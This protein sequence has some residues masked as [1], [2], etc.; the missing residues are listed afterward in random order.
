MRVSAQSLTR[1]AHSTLCRI[2]GQLSNACR[3]WAWCRS[4]K[5][6]GY[7]ATRYSKNRDGCTRTRGRSPMS[8]KALIGQ[9]AQEFCDGLWQ[10][11]DFWD[12]EHSEYERA[13]C[14]RLLTLLDGRRYAR[15]LEIGCGAGYFT[16]LLAGLADQIV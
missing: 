1:S 11:G 4:G 9:K 3:R 5:T 10:Q 8:E 7:G 2:L 6:S 13:R 16:R 14:A 12:F 15:A